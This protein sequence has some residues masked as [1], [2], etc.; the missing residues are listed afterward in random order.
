[1]TRMRASIESRATSVR[2]RSRSAA[3]IQRSDV[4]IPSGATRRS[5]MPVVAAIF[6]I[7]TCPNAAASSAEV[8]TQSGTADATPR[9]RTPRVFVCLMSCLACSQGSWRSCE[10]P[11][12]E[13]PRPGLAPSAPRDRAEMPCCTESRFAARAPADGIDS[14]RHVEGTKKPFRKPCRRRDLRD[15]QPSDT[16]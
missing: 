6:S 11:V 15:P 16:A 4:Q 7:S 2:S 12:L 1:V 5:W 9:M 14:A 13:A 10:D 3:A 8:T